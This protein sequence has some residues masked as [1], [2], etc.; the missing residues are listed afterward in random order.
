MVQNTLI[1]REKDNTTAERLYIAFELGDK[2]WKMGMS[3]GEGKT[4]VY[5]VAAGD[6]GALKEKIE[7]AKRAFGLAA[8]AEVKSCY[9]AGRDGFWLHRWL[10]AEGVDNK[11]VDSSSIEV[12][13]RKRRTKTD[14]LDVGSLLRMLIRY[15]GGEKRVWSVLRVPSEQAEDL[16][17]PHRELDRL[18]KERTQHTNRIRS[19]LVLHNVRLAKIGGKQWE[20]ELAQIR[21]HE[22]KGLPE[23]LRSELERESRRLALVEEQIGQ[24]EKELL[25]ELKDSDQEAV[26]KIRCLMLLKGIGQ[27]S[28]RVFV[29]EMFGWRKFRNRRQVGAAIGL[30]P[31][32][33]L[34]GQGGKEQGIS[35]A[36][37]GR[38]RHLAV[39]ISWV[40][41]RY[42]PGSRLSQW[43]QQ[44]FGGGGKRMRR[45]GIV[46]VARRLMISL[47]QYLQYGVV[48]EGAVLKG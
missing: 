38:V 48:P 40:W 24:V 29:R 9:E 31:S 22:G 23:K 46:A 3:K 10:Q 45:I 16:R 30:V 8:A 4:R 18:G 15:E 37:N 12:N 43:F 14:R 41:L 32:P 11:V 36:G 33:Y 2:W 25:Q 34:S 35:K 5:T 20:N 1:L 19:L 21:T 13:R 7:K 28:A 39:E 42:Q 44:R 47:W 27:R 26:E 17:R 6:T